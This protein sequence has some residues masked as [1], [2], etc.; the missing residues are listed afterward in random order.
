VESTAPTDSSSSAVSSIAIAVI[1]AEVTTTAMPLRPAPPAP[2][3]ASF[4]IAKFAASVCLHH[5]ERR[6]DN[7][8]HNR[9]RAVWC[10]RARD[11]I[12]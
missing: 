3:Q 12:T 1:R 5:N 10:V 2:D 11:E 6:L 9:S 4:T 7:L 8:H